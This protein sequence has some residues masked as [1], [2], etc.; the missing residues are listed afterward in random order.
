MYVC[1]CLGTPSTTEAAERSSVL[2]AAHA[3]AADQQRPTPELGCCTTG[4]VD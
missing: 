3:A 4:T 1:V 2:S